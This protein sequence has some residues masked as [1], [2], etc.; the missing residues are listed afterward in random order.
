ML[1]HNF[2]KDRALLIGIFLMFIFVR[3]FSQSHYFFV[4][5]D[6]GKYLGLAKNFPEHKLDNKEL[7]LTQ[8][9][10]YPYAIHYVSLSF[11]DH[12][13]GIIVSL[14]SAAI[15][16]FIVYKLAMMAAMNRYAAMFALILLSLSSIFI[17][18]S[19]NV[20]KESFSTMLILAALYKYMKLLKSG[21]MKDM[22]Y[23]SIFGILAGLTSDHAIFLIPGMI[24]AYFFLGN[25]V[26][27]S[28]ALLPF[29]FVVL[30]YSS[31]LGV[32]IYTYTNNNYYPAGWDGTIVKTEGWGLRQLISNHYFPEM[33]KYVP[34]GASL[35][36]GHYIYPVAY[37]A[38]LIIAPWPPGLRLS[39][40]WSLFSIKYI[41]QIIIYPLL[42]IFAAYAGYR[43]IKPVIS[44]RRIK[45]NVMLL[46]LMLFLIFL[47]P[48]H[49]K[50]NSTRYTVPSIIF[51]YIIMSHGLFI[52]M[53]DIGLFRFCKGIT[54]SLIIALLLYLPFY[55]Y[56]NPYF[57]LSKD[58]VV[59]ANAA[60]EFL[61]SLPK[62]GVMVQIG[63]TPELSYL[64][65]KRIVALAIDPSNIFELIEMYNINYLVYGDSYYKP[66]SQT[67]DEKD[68]I[69]YDT[70]KYIED[71]PKQF[72]F[73]SVV[74]ETYPWGASDSFHV[75]EVVKSG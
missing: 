19:T 48:V 10:L 7:F 32:R 8:R 50:I 31:W 26:K 1:S 11:E 2:K 58:K 46:Y 29:V 63:Y 3:L 4:S 52:L 35:E 36:L 38:N 66:F 44:K 51:L 20:L 14:L 68:I 42:F 24:A 5:G 72:R 75:Y 28:V 59:Q 15:T 12:V 60:A 9:P 45:G 18:L 16:F 6:Q 70:I 23:S 40:I 64:S 61:D 13:A 21:S 65:N 34:F 25:K 33:E 74:K 22:A 47:V 69:N 71:H 55:Y 62:D 30:S 67:A 17:G 53:K 39:S 27:L 43:V 54:L 41:M 56:N 37:M 57:L 49:Q 73:L